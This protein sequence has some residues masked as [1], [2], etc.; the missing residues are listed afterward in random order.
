VFYDF[1]FTPPG[2]V[3]GIQLFPIVE[4][5]T[6]IFTI[7]EGPKKLP[8]TEIMN[9]VPTVWLSDDHTGQTR[10]LEAFAMDYLIA[11]GHHWAVLLPIGD[12]LSPDEVAGIRELPVHWV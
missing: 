11:D 9:G 7:F 6:S 3:S 2:H 10:P 8:Y 1:I 4:R 12:W 5:G